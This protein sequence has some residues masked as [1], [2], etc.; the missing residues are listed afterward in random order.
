MTK[1]LIPILLLVIM[2]ITGCSNSSGSDNKNIN[3]KNLTYSNLIDEDTQ[4]EVKNILIENNITKEQ[5]DYFIELV[6]DYNDKSS[7]EDMKT[8]KSNFTTINTPQVPYEEGKLAEIWDYNE[9]MYVDF[10]C[11]LTS[12]ILYKNLIRA[13]ENYNYDDYNL[14]FDLDTIQNNPMSKFS[15]DEV[16]KF[17]ALYASIPVEN[18]EDVSKLYETIVSEW[19][20]RKISFEENK[21]VSMINVYLHSPEDS[22]VFVGHAG[23]SIKTKDGILFVEKYAPSLPY[24]VSKFK[25]SNELKAYLM[26]RLDVN[27]S[28]NGAAKPIIMENYKLMN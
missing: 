8:S 25:D 13:D 28:D 4:N 22:I 2:L 11:R 10:N 19:K 14:M 20:E 16:T 1:K 27:T 12:F 7:L 21:N 3:V 17:K 15:D 6:K 23:I 5:A 9:V 26:N 18:T 24:Q